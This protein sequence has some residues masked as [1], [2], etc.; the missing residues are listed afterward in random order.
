M[1]YGIDRH[2]LGVIVDLQSLVVRITIPRR[3]IDDGPAVGAVGDIDTL[4]AGIERDSVGI[5]ADGH[6]GDHRACIRIGHRHH[7]VAAAA[8]QDCG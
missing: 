8:E 3:L 2:R 7:L 1:G 6:P 5:V 4:H